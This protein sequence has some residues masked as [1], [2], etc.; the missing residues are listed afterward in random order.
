M[1]EERRRHERRRVLRRARIVFRNGHSTV[2]CVLLDLSDGGARLKASGL[3]ALPERFE[4]RIENGP[5]YLAAVAYRHLEATGVRFLE[6][7]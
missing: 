6:A 3:L 2:D 1:V 7:A 5:S 4:L